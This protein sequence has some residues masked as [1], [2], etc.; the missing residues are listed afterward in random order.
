MKHFFL[1]LLIALLLNLAT[2][3]QA[4]KDSL[5][6]VIAGEVCAELN[7]NNE[8][9]KSKEDL[10]ANLGLAMLPSFSKHQE[11][12]KEY[13]DA[14]LANASS[15][16]QF[17]EQV[18]MRLV[19]ECPQFLNLFK[20]NKEAF[21]E[22]ADGTKAKS[23]G[24]VSGTLLKIVPGDFTYFIIKSDNGKSEKIWWQEYFKGSE[25]SVL[26]ISINQLKC[27]T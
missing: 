20:D 18:G 11:E 4:K 21:M 9:F 14:D 2:F 1:L 7:S 22:L 5:L 26:L 8:G 24:T 13:F 10:A 17:G 16:E 23:S 27:I 3:A 6:K 15:M 19:T 25:K 12:L